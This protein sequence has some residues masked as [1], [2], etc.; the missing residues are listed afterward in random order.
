MKSLT[1]SELPRL[2]CGIGTLKRFYSM[3]WQ[4]NSFNKRNVFMSRIRSNFPRRVVGL[5]HLGYRQEGGGHKGWGG[6]V[7][8][9]GGGG[10]QACE[11]E[12]GKRVVKRLM[13]HRDLCNIETCAILRLVQY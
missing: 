10:G 6:A 8:G 1:S 12:T 5:Q 3:C 11:E 2:I 13:Q 9:S 7:R 4:K